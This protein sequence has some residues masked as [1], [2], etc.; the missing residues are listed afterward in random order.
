MYLCRVSFLITLDLYKA[1]F[2]GH[3]K[4]EYKENICKRWPMP[5]SLWKKLLRL[6]A[7]GF[8]NQVLLDIHCWWSEE[9]CSQHSFSSSWWVSHVLGFMHQRVVF[10][11]WRVQRFWSGKRF[12]LWVHL[13]GLIVESRDK[14]FV[15]DLKLLFIIVNYFLERFPLKFF[16]VKLV[17]FIGF[18]GSLYL[19]LVIF[20]LH[21]FDMI[22]IFVCFYRFY[23]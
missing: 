19:V 12:L 8:C 5:Y 16:T 13:R 7:F 3:H 21:D 23:S 6:C 15:L 4:R 22:L 20:L 2:R 10:I 9:L 14:G 1:Y 18:P 17:C 11:Y